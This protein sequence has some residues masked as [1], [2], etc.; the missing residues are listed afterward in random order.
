MT[1]A[2]NFI[3]IENGVNF[4]IG[5]NSSKANMIEVTLDANDTYTIKF[6]KF[7]N[8]RMTKEYKMIEAKK[9]ILKEMNGIYCDELQT[10]F[11]NY[12]GMYTHL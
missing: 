10:V 5:K 1:G 7:T 11:T 3:A 6:I 9:E 2:K 4:K 12:T 8:W